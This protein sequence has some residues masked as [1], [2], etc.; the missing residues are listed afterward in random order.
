MK[1]PA[2]VGE[3][4][5]KTEKYKENSW[6]PW[7]ESQPKHNPDQTN[8][9]ILARDGRA[10]RLPHSSFRPL[11]NPRLEKGILIQTFFVLTLCHLHVM[12]GTPRNSNW[13]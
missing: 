13:P 9:P 7:F 12:D 5:R 2:L 10:L 6:K 1:K 11:G 8:L 4:E 3:W